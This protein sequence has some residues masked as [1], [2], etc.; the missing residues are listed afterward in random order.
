MKN[1]RTIWL[2]ILILL[3][4][5]GGGI[6]FA[7][8]FPDT[9]QT[10]CYDAAGNVIPCPQPGEAFYGQDAQCAGPARSY[11]KLGE[12]GV[13][14]PDTA[15]QAGGWIMIKDNVTGLVWEIKTD[16]ESIHDRDNTYNWYDSSNLFI[17][18]LNAQNFGGYSDWRMPTVKELSSLVNSGTYDPAIDTAW[19]PHTR[20]SRYWSST[21]DAGNVSKAWRVEF[22]SGYVYSLGDKYDCYSVRAVRGESLSSSGCLV[23]NGDGT[24]TNTETGLMWQKATAPGEYTWQEALAYAAGLTLG[25]YSDWRLPNRNEQQTLIDYSRYDPAIDPLLQEDTETNYWL[26]TT[27]AYSTDDAWSVY[28]YTGAVSSSE[29][30]QSS[31]VRAVRDW[32]PSKAMP[33]IPLLLLKNP[34]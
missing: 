5:T 20:W 27:D 7:G 13:Q 33:W 21:P 32:N 14:L 15:T 25:G 8:Q 24:V 31:C 18:T 1:K 29:K 6:S 16:D 19:F 3:L 10:T 23:D 4:L 2:F 12:N 28:F 34:E 26:S 11:I 30:S 17:V 22:G 9:G